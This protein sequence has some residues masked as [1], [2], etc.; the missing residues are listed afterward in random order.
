MFEFSRT[1]FNSM[2]YDDPN[3][4]L[5]IVIKEIPSFEIMEESY[6]LRV[7]TRHEEEDYIYRDYAIEHHTQQEKHSYPHLQFKFHTEEI[8]SFI[9]KL[10]FE[11][12]DEYKRAILG[13]IY[14]IKSVLE[15]LEKYKKGITEEMLV[16]DLVNKLD[17]EGDF[18]MN[19]IFESINKNG[20]E[21]KELE[22]TR[23]KIKNLEKNYL[24]NSFLGERNVNKIIEIHKKKRKNV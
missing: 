21:L 4:K 5:R 23:D 9:I 3:S 10:Y 8:G 24:L 16:L 1:Y 19:K 20:I 12:S 15:N 13:F 22:K 2:L 18:L 14:K 17:K 7:K 6:S 11:N